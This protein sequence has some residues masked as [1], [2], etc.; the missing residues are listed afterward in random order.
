MIKFILKILLFT[1]PFF[2]IFIYGLFFLPTNIDSNNMLKSSLD[3]RNRLKSIKKPKMV[4]IAGS[5]MAF[6]LDSKMIEEKFNYSVV[7]M[8]ISA[9][10]GLHYMVLEVKPH[11][12]KGDI[13]VIG[14]EYDQFNADDVFYG[15]G[16]AL[17]LL[18][19]IHK[20]DFIELDF[21]STS[22]FF[23]QIMEYDLKK[24]KSFIINEKKE[25]KVDKINTEPIEIYKAYAK[26]NVYIRSGFNKNGDMIAHWGLDSHKYEMN[27]KHKIE[28]PSNEV[29]DFLVDF[30]QE[31]NDKGVIVIFIPPP[32]Y[33]GYFEK[34]QENIIKVTKKLEEYQLSYI[35]SPNR[36]SF[37]DSLFYDTVYHL[38]KKGVDKRTK[39]LIEDITKY[40][41]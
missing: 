5:S 4:F 30:K 27:E 28:P 21:R 33:A 31:M 17:P 36:Y 38:N 1:I 2:F 37:P 7:N 9:A 32:Y 12:K 26:K 14:A 18:F 11:L 24:I 41:N 40:L 19:E 8:G 16:V 13:L 22:H 15:Q 29:M 39:Y 34:N 10:I 35:A 6:G 25:Q 23:P 20:D 3:K